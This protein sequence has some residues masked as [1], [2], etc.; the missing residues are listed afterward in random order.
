MRLPSATSESR[1]DA[2]AFTVFADAAKACVEFTWNVRKV[3]VCLHFGLDS[4]AVADYEALAANLALEWAAEM[5]QRQSDDLVMGDVVVYDLSEEGAPKY[6]NSDENGSP[7]TKAIDSAPNNTSLIVSHRSVDTGRSSRGRTYFP[8]VSEDDIVN[9]VLVGTFRDSVLTNWGQMISGIEVSTG[10][11]FV[12]AQ[13]FSEGVQLTTGVTRDVTTE[14]ITKQ[15]G[16]QRRRQT[17]S[18]T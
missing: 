18:A 4:P 17:Q 9:G 1:G 8:G 11:R 13:R 16:S 7:G 2:M 15:L 5:L 14:I 10:W 12:I 6:T 3:S